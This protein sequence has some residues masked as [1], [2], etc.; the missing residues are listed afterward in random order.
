M[1]GR[2]YDINNHHDKVN[3]KIHLKIPKGHSEAVNRRRIDN[4]MTKTKNDK[5]TD[6]DFQYT[7]QKTK[8]GAT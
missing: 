1:N 8:E 6:N 4:T 2:R 5:R 7:T 3:T